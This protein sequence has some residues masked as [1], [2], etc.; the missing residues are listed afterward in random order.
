MLRQ[1][2]KVQTEIQEILFKNRKKKEKKKTT[3][4]TFVRVVQYPA[5]LWFLRAWRS[6]KLEW[7]RSGQT[8]AGAA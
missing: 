7:T 4:I 3:K 8:A 1:E 5:R 2:A 6:L